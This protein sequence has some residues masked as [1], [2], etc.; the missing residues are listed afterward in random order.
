MERMHRD[1]STRQPQSKRAKAATTASSTLRVGTRVGGW[2]LTKYLAGGGNGQVWTVTSERPGEYVMKLL[3]T[4]RRPDAYRLGRFADEIKFLRDNPDQPGVLPLVD[5]YVSADPAELSWY[6]MPRAMP[7]NDVLGTDPAVGTVLDAMA[8]YAETLADLAER[9][10]GHRDIKPDNLFRLDDEWVVGD[11]G[12]VTYP[13]KDPRTDHGRKLGPADYLAPEMRDDADNAHAEPADVWALA[14]TTWVLLTGQ[15]LPLPGTHRPEDEAFSLRDRITFRYVNELDLLLEKATQM[16]PA[17]RVTM[18]EFATE[19]RA[20]L[21]EAPEDAP[22][23]DLDAL[24]QRIRSQSAVQVR[25]NQIAQDRRVQVNEAFGALEAIP[26]A[27]WNDLN[28]R[29]GFSGQ[30]GMRQAPAAFQ[31]LGLP[32]ST[33]YFAEGA[34]GILFSPDKP[35]GRA[36][37]HIEV[38]MRMQY[39][40]SP[41]QVVA[42]LDVEHYFAGRSDTRRIWSHSTAVPIGSAQFAQVV[43]AIGSGFVSS[44][45]GAMQQVA[46][47][48]DLP[49]DEVPAWFTQTSGTP[50]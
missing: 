36:R 18:R 26:R 32:P 35:A 16:D 29:I 40:D 37:I 11:F 47:I 44:Y 22:K 39:E 8:S 7:L 10:I 31:L 21:A 38:A 12:L 33:P 46:R 2:T 19:L 24:Q 14:K 20:C 28:Y 4:S 13:E 17:R 49:E 50:A 42:V 23:P 15:G 41:T 3:K 1:M 27:V 45:E 6:V 25:K 43:A 30:L 34:S 5:S 9:G 48:L